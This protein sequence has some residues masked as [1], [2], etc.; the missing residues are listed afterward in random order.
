MSCAIQLKRSGISPLILDKNRRGG[1]LRFANL[2]ENYPGFPGG[3]R[4]N[5][6]VKKIQAQFRAEKLKITNRLVLNVENSNNLFRVLTN[7]G[8]MI[9]K[10]LVIATGTLS[11]EFSDFKIHKNLKNFVFN[12]IEK[13]VNAKN[14]NIVIVGGGDLAYDYSINLGSNNRITLLYR[15]AK[16]KCI[17]LLQKRAKK[18]GSFTEFNN[19]HLKKITKCGKNKIKIAFTYRLIERFITADFL[20][21]AI[22]RRENLD[23]LSE[24]SKKSINILKKKEYLHFI[25]DVANNQY[26]QSV[27]SAGDGVKTAMK[28]YE[29]ESAKL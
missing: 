5:L 27:V 11:K 24:T 14:K 23:F 13:I 29:I 15:S 8:D 28:I 20:I 10:Y 9:S 17:A 21:F 3:I 25:G 16:P 19:S 2:V 4:G 22:G 18:L 7:K 26:R 12:D 6:L 1:M